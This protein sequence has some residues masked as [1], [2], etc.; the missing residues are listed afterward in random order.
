LK[1][2]HRTHKAAEESNVRRRVPVGARDV[3]DAFDPPIEEDVTNIRTLTMASHPFDVGAVHRAHVEDGSPSLYLDRAG[4]P[5]TH[6]R[7][8]WSINQ[9]PRFEENM[10]D[11]FAVYSDI[12]TRHVKILEL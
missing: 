7:Q 12:V 3:F 9:T 4:S 6:A 8:L 2:R 1:K 10:A 5:A 11:G